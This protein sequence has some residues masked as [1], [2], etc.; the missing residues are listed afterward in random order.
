MSLKV[1]R[2]TLIVTPPAGIGYSIVG[3]CSV[4]T[5]IIKTA[6][7]NSYVLSVGKL[8]GSVVFFDS[9]CQTP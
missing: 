3:Q 7:E 2:R 4:E 8:S 1:L 9:T 5:A 6:W